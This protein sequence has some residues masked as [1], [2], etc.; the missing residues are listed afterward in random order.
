MVPQQD[1]GTEWTEDGTRYTA[2]DPYGLEAGEAFL[3]YGPETP[4]EGLD[5]EFLIW[6]PG[7]ALLETL[8][9]WGLWNQETGCGF[10]TYY[11]W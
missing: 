3:L 8:E 2:A 6:W 7:Y 11:Q 9:C 4:T 5:E 1:T 10:F